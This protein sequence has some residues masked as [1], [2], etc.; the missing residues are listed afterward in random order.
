MHAPVTFLI[1]DL[2]LVAFHPHALRGAEVDDFF[3][4]VK[5]TPIPAGMSAT[6]GREFPAHICLNCFLIYPDI[7]SPGT[8]KRHIS[9]GNGS[10]AAVGA[11]VK[12]KLKLVREGWT[13]KFVL[14]FMGQLVAEFLSVVA[15]PLAA[16]LAQAAGGSPQIGARTA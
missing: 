7:V 14:V 13:V 8:D 1:V 16:G 9:P 12:L 2:Q 15:R 4:D 10:H 5:W 3:L 6:I 11:S